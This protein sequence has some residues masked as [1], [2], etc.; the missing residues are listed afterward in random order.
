MEF[1]LFGR[2]F[3]QKTGILELM[4]DLGQALAGDGEVSMLGGGNPASIPAV[5]EV[6]R[7]RLHEI[8]LQ[9][10]GVELLLAQYDTPQ[11]NPAFLQALARFLKE[12]FGWNVGPENIGVTNGSQNAFFLLFNLLAGD[13]GGGKSRSVLFPLAPEYVGY[14]DQALGSGHFHSRRPQVVLQEFPF[15][16]YFVDFDGLE[17]HEDTGALCASRP[18]NPTGNVLTQDEVVHLAGLCRRAGVPF[19]LD[20]AYGTP[21]PGILFEEVDPFWDESTVLVLSLSKLGLPATRTGILVAKPEIIQAVTASNAILNL[22]S[23]GIGQSLVLPYVEN[24]ALWEL[25]RQIIRPYYLAARDFAVQA[26]VEIFAQ[27]FPYRIHRPQG[28]LFLWVWFQGLPIPTRELYE[29]LKAR[30]VV[31]VPGEYFFFGME[32]ADKDWNHRRECLRLNYA[33]PKAEILRGLTILAE[34]VERAFGASER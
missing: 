26:T 17:L 9:D 11:G 34:E 6:W 13:W 19:L 31:V 25:S 28:A 16:K 21:F 14:A 24:G 7:Q 5:N 22:A 29:R 15:F 20:N 1:S 27:R 2:N 4:D 33:R 30:A 10:S 12:R 18:T 8:L 3:T 32:D 23:S